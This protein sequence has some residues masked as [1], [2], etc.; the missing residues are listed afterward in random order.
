MLY[1]ADRLQT[2]S[3]RQRGRLIRDYLSVALLAIGLALS[4]TA[5]SN[6]FSNNQAPVSIAQR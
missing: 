6:A 3:K 4:A 1:K 5:V 2:V